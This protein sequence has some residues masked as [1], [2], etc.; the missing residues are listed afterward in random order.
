MIRKH[1]M[2]Y[3]NMIVH[4]MKIGKT[5]LMIAMTLDAVK[6]WLSAA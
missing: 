2:R 1:D 4:G 5:L 3:E 6:T